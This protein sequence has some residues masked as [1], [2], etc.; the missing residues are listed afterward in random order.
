[1]LNKLLETQFEENKKVLPV[2]R[3]NACPLNSHPWNTV[4]FSCDG[5]LQ[6]DAR[7]NPSESA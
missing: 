6:Q 1:M 2:S 5:F 4:I 3:N 7:K